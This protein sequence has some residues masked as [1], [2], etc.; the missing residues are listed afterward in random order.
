MEGKNEYWVQA[1]EAE[2]LL[3]LG[4]VRRVRFIL[5]EA[6]S[7]PD[8]KPSWISSTR[9][10]ALQIAGEYK[11]PQILKKIKTAFPTLGIVAFQGMYLIN[12]EPIQDFHPKLRD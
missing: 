2:A 11:D 9:K 12:L 8:A 5:L 1:T 3:L 6:V 10:Q 7:L 4:S